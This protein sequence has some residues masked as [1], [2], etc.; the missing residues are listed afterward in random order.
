MNQDN[1]TRARWEGRQATAMRT[2]WQ[3]TAGQVSLRCV[4]RTGDVSGGALEVQARTSKGWNKVIATGDDA[5]Q[6]LQRV[7]TTASM[8]KAMS[9][10]QG[11]I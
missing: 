6:L 9:E 1:A 11:G 4:I 2:L 5:F 3:L 8:R 7:T 10:H